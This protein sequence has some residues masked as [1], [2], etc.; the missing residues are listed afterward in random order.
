MQVCA[1]V[2]EINLKHDAALSHKVTAVS[3]FYTQ[4]LNKQVIGSTVQIKILPSVFAKFL[5]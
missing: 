4:S 5:F 3:D 1:F 2:K